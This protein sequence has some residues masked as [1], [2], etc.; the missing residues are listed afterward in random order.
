MSTARRKKTGRLASWTSIDNS[1]P[2]EANETSYAV[3]GLKNGTVYSF[4][5]R[6][7]NEVG[8]GDPSAEAT[9]EVNTPYFPARQDARA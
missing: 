5:V 3:T 4:R 8:P 9:A 7:V 6:A 1:A 2:G